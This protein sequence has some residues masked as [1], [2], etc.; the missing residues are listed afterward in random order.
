M[1]SILLASAGHIDHGK[2]AL[3]KAL[4]GFESDSTNEEKRRGITIDLS[5]SHLTKDDVNVA[6]IDVPGHENLLKTMI[7]GAFG[8]Q[9]ALLVVSSTEGLKA[10]SL[11]HIRILEFLGIK[12][13]ILCITKCDLA[14]SK[15]RAEVKKA[16]LD[17]LEKH[18]FKLLESFELSIFDEGSIDT[19]RQFLLSL[20]IKS[21]QISCLPRYYVDRLF[22][23]KGA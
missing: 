13:I 20:R 19:L 22:N 11:E 23:I 2:T 10:Q 21:E 17:E 12:N 8:A 1:S 16:C 4:N 9:G 5:F 6:F 7:S 14:D 3:I 15:R 18:D